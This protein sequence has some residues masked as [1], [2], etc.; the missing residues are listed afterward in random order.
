MCVGCLFSRRKRY[1]CLGVIVHT[2]PLKLQHRNRQASWQQRI[3]QALWQHK[4][5][6]ASWQ[7]RNRQTS[8]Q[9]RI[10]RAS[11][12]HRNRLASWQH[13]NRRVSWQF[14]LQN[15]DDS[16][17]EVLSEGGAG[18]DVSE[19]CLFESPR[20]TNMRSPAAPS[21]VG[22]P[23]IPR[24]LCD[25]QT[26]KQKMCMCPSVNDHEAACIMQKAW[27]IQWY[28]ISSSFHNFVST[29]AG[30]SSENSACDSS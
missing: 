11:W 19:L 10:K 6:L 16:P 9:Q 23:G 26:N 17:E 25:K 12:Q 20:Q 27:T 18:S 22:K 13:R 7:L 21:T 4:N 2:Q 8:W 30:R 1:L 29:D 28:I 14:L 15:Y 24:E 3:K 5:R